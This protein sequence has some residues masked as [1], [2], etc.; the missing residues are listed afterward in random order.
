[1]EGRTKT[2]RPKRNK[3]LE[4]DIQSKTVCNQS[5]RCNTGLRKSKQTYN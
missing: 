5:I 4:Q 1:M 2:L 3:S